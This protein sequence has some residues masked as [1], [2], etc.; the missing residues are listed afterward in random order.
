MPSLAGRSNMAG[1]GM[2]PERSLGDA[3]SRQGM[4]PSSMAAAQGMR[5]QQNMSGGVRPGQNLMGGPSVQGPGG[6]DLARIQAE[7]ARRNVGAQLGPRNA[8][9]A[10]Y[11]QG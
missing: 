4:N 6:P 3:R 5:M 2:G 7:M 8:A 9:L 1:R 10:G 11:M